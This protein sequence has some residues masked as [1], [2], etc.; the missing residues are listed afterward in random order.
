VTHTALPTR[1]EA[2]GCL[3]KG[4]G[5]EVWSVRDRHTGARYALK[6]LAHDATEHEMNALVREAVALS[7][8]E[9]LGAPRVIWFGRLGAGGQPYMVRE[10]VEGKSLETWI[11][12]ADT[13]KSGESVRRALD[14]LAR[15]A[16][17]LTVLHRAGLLH[18]DVKPANVIV[19]PEGGATLVDLGL[20]APWKESGSAPRGLTPRYAAPE[21][22]SG[23]PL[24]V[25]AEVYALGVILT[26]ILQSA[27]AIELGPEAVVA[28]AAVADRARSQKPTDR[29]P[30]ADEF[31]SAL[32][33]ASGGDQPASKRTVAFEWPVVG[34]DVA[35]AKLLESALALAAGAALCLVGPAGSGRSI[36]LRRLAWSLGIAGSHVAWVDS[37]TAKNPELLEAE[38]STVEPT[39]AIVLVDDAD[40]LAPTSVSLLEGLRQRGARLVF[41]GEQALFSKASSFEVNRLDARSAAELVRRV[42]PSLTD[43]ALERLIAKADAR[44]GQLRS[45]VRRLAQSTVTS[46]KDIERLIG[47]NPASSEVP[48][49]PLDAAVHYLDHGRYLEARTLLEGSARD[50]AERPVE[51]AMAQ[52]RLKLGLGDAALAL[53]T[54]R[55][56]ERE[57]Q[58]SPELQA[59]WKLV[60]SRA[61]IGV[62]D[63]AQGLTLAREVENYEGALGLE[64]G[65]YRGLAELL[66]G[67]EAQALAT[68]KATVEAAERDATPRLVGLALASFG[69]ALQR[70]DRTDEARAAYERAIPFAEEASDAATL[71]TLQLNLASLLK[72]SGD[73]AAA[74]RHFEAAVDMCGRS[75]RRS[76]ERQALLNLAN[77]DLYLGRLARARVNIDEL[78]RESADLP[79]EA[80]AQLSGLQAELAARQAR[81]GDAARQYDACAQAYEELGRNIDAAEALFESVLMLARAPHADARELRKKLERGRTIL[82]D[83]PAHRALSLLAEARVAELEGNEDAARSAVEAALSAARE[84]SQREWIWRA[85]EVRAE[86]G[87]KA[88]LAVQ[89]RRDR[90]EALVALE[91]IGARLPRDLREVYWND[92]RRAS[93]R[94]LVSGSIGHAATEYLPFLSDAL[95]GTKDGPTAA[96]GSI[97][98]MTTTPLEQRLARILE[99]N[100][101]LVG[102]HD[103][104]R[105]TGRIIDY[106]VGLLRAERGYVLLCDSED[107]L[108]VHASRSRS[109]DTSHHEFSRSIARGVIASREPIV[110]LNARDDARMTSFASVHQLMLMAVACVPIFSRGGEAIGALYL[111]TRGRSANHF[112][113]ELPTLRAFA[114]QIAIALENARLLGENKSR[115][116]ELELTVQELSETQARLRELLGDR[117]KKL[118]DARQKLRD[119]RDTLRGHFGYQGLVGTSEAMRR[120]Y[121]LIERVRDTDIPVLITGESGTGKEVV[122]RAI[123]AA[124]PR[125]SGKF[126][127]INCGAVPENLLE[128]E[129]FGHMR[130]AFTGADRDRKGLFRECQGGTILLDEIGETPAKMQATLL[131]V[132]QDRKVRPV[133]GTE[134]QEVDARVIFAT[135]RDLT[136]MVA[137]GAFREDLYYRIVVVEMRIPSLRERREDI[138]Q[139]VDHFLGLFAARYRREKRGVSREAMRALMAH[140]WPGNVRQLENVLLN[141]WVLSE[142]EELEAEDLGLKES[143]SVVPASRPGLPA[144]AAHTAPRRETT[145]QHQRSERDRIIQALEASN[146]NRV[147]AAE[148]SG[149]PRR[150]FYRRLRDYGIQ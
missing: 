2:L 135:N 109:G 75:G 71:S 11:T 46:E 69:L 127:G 47:E 115:A 30:S 58:A 143:S 103:L 107:Q 28:L 48:T 90:E 16:D 111:E 89:A 12:E 74:I 133:G 99:I 147:K 66:S 57:A 104:E 80:R 98:T 55:A 31:S 37:A 122:A 43:H 33:A 81:F 88:G 52:A 134:E 5:G 145:S 142:G 129:L 40:A 100:S 126:L 27:T 146:W 124:S 25:R 38:V 1:Y 60:M 149:I 86:L 35:S 139:L 97:S 8:L 120:V 136:E 29:F 102:E 22:L 112:E 138:P 105:L 94:G 101:E 70:A 10:L 50:F 119:A 39:A 141:A 23:K 114:D 42:I 83:A 62:G 73:V 78:A 7:G 51:A 21:L 53:E 9:G 63:F 79:R 54:L 17:Q 150:T 125:A 24:T 108:S 137:R 113:L 64:A 68:L 96:R 106:A 117:T 72:V 13:D 118:N 6:V 130:G 20:A 110:S 85:L 144:P 121:S 128:S 49:D 77:L 65:M 132:L 140:S 26:E 3:G 76:A 61:S 87:E 131:R 36:L 92:P 84:S 41:V 4:G 59:R 18:G 82:A 32:C 45:L 56:V 91:E 148:L 95:T 123:H 44:P 116:A 14:A 67:H 34:I 15:A 93:L 19:T